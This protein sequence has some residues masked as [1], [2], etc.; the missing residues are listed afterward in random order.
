MLF[1]LIVLGISVLSLAILGLAGPAHRL[2]MSLD[3]AD[4]IVL[5]AAHG[6]GA[7]AVVAIVAGVLAYR[8]RAWLR[9]T[10]AAAAVVIGVTGFVIG[11]DAYRRV[12]LVASFYVFSSVLVY[13]P[14]FTAVIA[15]RADSPNRL[16]RTPQ[17]AE[18]QRQSYS[19]LAPLTVAT[20]PEQTFD[21]VLSVAQ[22]RGWEIVTA[23]KSSGRIEAT[24]TTRWFGFVDDISIRLTAWGSGTRVDVRSV[25]RTGIGDAGRN[26]DRIRGFLKELQR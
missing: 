23:D 15:R 19:D 3:S 2:G 17:L 13:P 7:A 21:R 16:D 4:A 25:S 12:W 10:V 8:G 22:A 18:L 5:W 14:T 26:A 11:F 6:C 1:A 24:D 9:L 20:R